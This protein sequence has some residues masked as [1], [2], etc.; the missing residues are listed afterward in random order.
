[1]ALRVLL[2]AP[3]CQLHVQIQR[4]CSVLNSDRQPEAPSARFQE[5]GSTQAGD[6]PRLLDRGETKLGSDR[7]TGENAARPQAAGQEICSHC[8]DMEC[9]A[10]LASLSARF[11]CLCAARASRRCRFRVDR[12]HAGTR[13]KRGVSRPELSAA[14]VQSR[15]HPAVG[16]SVYRRRG[17]TGVHDAGRNSSGPS[18]SG[19]AFSGFRRS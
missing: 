15:W 11:T 3:D 18:R 1:M 5:C 12:P 16:D 13:P 7:Y 9:G 2:S 14:R 8:S 17:N 6:L 4:E 10:P 19:K